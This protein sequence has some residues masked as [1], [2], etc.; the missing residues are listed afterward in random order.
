LPRYFARKPVK[1]KP[2]FVDTLCG[3]MV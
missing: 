2:L 3:S 1:G